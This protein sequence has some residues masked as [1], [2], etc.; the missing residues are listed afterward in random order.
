MISAKGKVH[1]LSPRYPECGSKSRHCPL[2]L[3]LHGVHALTEISLQS[4]VYLPPEKNLI[5]QG[6]VVQYRP[7][8]RF[9]YNGELS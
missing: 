8:D 2:R 7:L 5:R 6:H 3:K 4:T 1:T 9:I